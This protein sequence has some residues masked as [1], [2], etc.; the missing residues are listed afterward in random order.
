MED[1]RHVKARNF[2]RLA[3]IALILAAAVWAIPRLIIR[4][5]PKQGV[6]KHLAISL[7]IQ[8]ISTQL[9]VYKSA[10]Y[11]FPTSEQGLRALVSEPTTDSR[12]PRWEQLFREMPKDPWQNDYIYRCPGTR[13]PR[14]YDLFSAG[15][16]RKPDT[17][18]DDWGG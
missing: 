17:A 13:N 4:F 6:G 1:G 16:D 18:D 12:P 9:K 5:G 11:F 2:I 10:N 8:A 14:G 15:P 3:V 7:D